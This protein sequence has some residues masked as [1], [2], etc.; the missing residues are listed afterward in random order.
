MKIPN[1]KA[2]RDWCISK[3]QLKG[4][5][6]E[7]AELDATYQQ[8]T[9]YTDKKISTLINSAPET[10]DTLK[11]IADAMMENQDVVKAL[12]TAIG[13]KANASELNSH[14]SDGTIH[15]TD[16]ERTNMEDANSKKH[17]HEN[18]GV[19]DGITSELVTAWNNKSEFSGSYNDLADKPDLSSAGGSISED[20]LNEALD[21]KQDKVIVNITDELSEWTAISSNTTDKLA[22]IT[23]GNNKFVAVGEL[24]AIYY[25]EDGIAWLKGISDAD[26]TF[27]G[28]AYGNGRF[29]AVDINAGS[30]YYSED[31]VT[32]SSGDNDGNPMISIAYGNGKFIA[33]GSTGVYYSEDGITWFAGS[34]TDS[35]LYSVAYGNGRFVA[36]KPNAVYYSK[37]G[38]TWSP[39]RGVKAHTMYSVTYGRGKFLA[40]GSGGYIH[41]SADGISW[42]V[43]NS[44]IGEHL[45]SVTY[46]RGR[47]VA[48]GD[49]GAVYYSTD[50]KTWTDD[51]FAENV[52]LYGVVYADNKYIAVGASGSAYYRE[53]IKETKNLEDTIKYLEENKANKEDLTAENVGALPVDGTA[54]SAS[55]VVGEAGTSNIN[56]HVWFSHGSEET[57]RCYSDNFT[58]N[59]STNAITCDTTGT[60]SKASTVIDYNDPTNPIQI[61]WRN[62][63]LTAEQIKGFA[64]YTADDNSSNV[65]IKDV[66]I[67]V[68]Q[69]MLKN[70]LLN[71]VYPVG[72]I[73]M[74]VNNVSPASFLG[75]TWTAWGSG[76]V[77]VGV[78]TSDTNFSTVEKTGGASSVSSSHSHTVNSHYH[79]TAGHTLTVN[80][81]PAHN[82]K[83][84]TGGT[85]LAM[86]ADSGVTTNGIS[87]SS[88][89]WW[90]SNNK[91]SASIANTGGGASHSHGNTGN[92]SPGTD[93]KTVTSST[94]QPYITCY[95]WKR[96][97]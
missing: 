58:Y 3:F 1:L 61:G 14:T 17:A 57:K 80:E 16:A 23:Y 35:P 86:H 20:V 89:A 69:S 56:R 50:G 27:S 12:E 85:I 73:Y 47:F 39:G 84:T 26:G 59:P 64:A 51:G 24:G 55:S 60:A 52:D 91:N 48:V 33:T 43:R 29:V 81:I 72:S 30:T 49:A 18:K 74:S 40:C 10:L 37:D 11:E 79:T 90:N 78:N 15:I 44:G 71:M 88:T 76:R 5:Y 38:I 94:L 67:S 65:K 66:S 77:P 54:K 92:A 34:G 32:W 53:F 45:R 82:H 21:T 22:S 96:T 13:L 8:A 25:S 19:L 36:L 28:V 7:K 63:G 4:D 2:I 95:M 6:A 93:S 41:Y 83:L 97:A 68:L 31:G 87:M 46:G 62:E 75:G 70:D 42:Y 9:G